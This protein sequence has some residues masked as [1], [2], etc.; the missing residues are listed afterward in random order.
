MIETIKELCNLKGTSGW[1]VAVREY[2][3]KRIKPFATEIREDIMGNLIVF[4]KGQK[5]RNNPFMVCSHMDEV[6]LI[7]KDIT[8]EGYLS[9]DFAGGVDRRVIIGK[10]V[11]VG[12]KGIPGIIGMKAVHLTTKEERKKTPKLNELYIDIG[13]EKKATAE[14][15]VSLGDYAVFDSP[16]RELGENKIK[17]RAL[18]DRFGCG[19][20]LKL[21][22]SELLFDTY[23]VFTVQEEVGCRGAEIAAFGVKPDFALVLEATTAADIPVSEGSNKVCVLGKGAV[24]GC[25]DGGAI[26]DKR[27]FALLRGI[28]EEKGVSWQIKTRVA[29]ATDAR[30]IHVSRKGVRTTSLSLPTRYIHSPSCV[31]DIRDMESVFTLARELISCE[32][33]KLNA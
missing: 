11:L 8:E 12:E 9:F 13:C 5:R 23:F 17:A 29:G 24:I 27:L 16:I 26:Y 4:K 19:V 30:S 25:V 31:A 14:K 3:K 21:I 28:A 7:I 32:E 10:R 6:G 22:E 20:M 2:I 18:D 15:F 33:E 1:E